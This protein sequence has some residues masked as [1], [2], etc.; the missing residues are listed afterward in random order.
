MKK[1]VTMLLMLSMLLAMAACAGAP[2]A[3]PAASQ[4]E[5]TTAANAV[6]QETAPER[7]VITDSMDRNVEIPYSVERIVCVG[8]GA[9]RYTCYVG[10]ADRVVGV[11]D[12]ETKPGMS[13]LYNYV[14]FDLFQNLPVTGTNGEPF[15]EEIINVDPQ[16]IV[17]SSY[18][19]QDP[20]ELSQK[21]GIPVVVVPGSDTTLD[22]K[23]YVTIRIL[24][25]LYQL[26]DR[27]EDLTAYLKSIQKDLDDR[28]ASIAEDAK[29]TCYVGGVSFKGHHGFEGTEA[30][31]GPFE[32]IHVKNLANTTG[33]TGA[34]NIDVEQVLSWDPEII[35]L[36][37]N[38]MNLI[39]EDYGAHPEFYK[40]LT[41]V[42]EGKVYSQISFR[43]SASN[44]ETA[45]ADAYYAAC[46]M[47]PQQFQDIDPVEKAGEIFTKLL[48]SNPYHDLEE[49]GYAFCQITIGA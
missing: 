27:A 41:A 6:S 49:A 9:L 30:Y 42:Q 38:G 12:Y 16:V 48:G 19:S 24:G 26:E 18:A 35:F 40:A 32:L 33:Q 11:E 29:P 20:D 37:F 25:E 39:N 10:G 44:L 46:V 31:Y 4:A 47:Y 14:N 28:T 34:F 22:E 15:V 8:V 43:S 17:M 7:R 2:E 36:D 5:E 21:T 23:A 3:A 13:R 1:I 45:L